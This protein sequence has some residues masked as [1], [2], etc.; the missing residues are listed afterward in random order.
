MKILVKA[1]SLLAQIPKR[2]LRKTISSN[3]FEV[4]NDTFHLHSE[5]CFACE[6]YLFRLE[7]N[8]TVL[9]DDYY[10]SNFV[11]KYY[12]CD[13]VFIQ[14]HMISLLGTEVI[15]NSTHVRSI[16]F[17]SIHTNIEYLNSRATV[18][19]KTQTYCERHYLYALQN[20]K[21]CPKPKLNYAEV[22]KISSGKEQKT[23][24]SLFFITNLKQTN[25]HIQ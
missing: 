10:F 15:I 19:S 25:Q 16:Q 7:S 13:L 24:L 23:L 9:L 12:N 5:E 18:M 4:I 14:E 8:R 17:D 6:Q 11:Q 20:D 1:S 2:K 22:L 3:L 21:I